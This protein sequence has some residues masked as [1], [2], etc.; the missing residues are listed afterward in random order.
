LIYR[1][2][3]EGIVAEVKN[4]RLKR[5]GVESYAI[6]LFLFN[7]LARSL[8]DVAL[9]P[10]ERDLAEL[11]MV[12][13]TEEIDLIREAIRIAE[14]ALT[15]ITPR[16]VPG[17]T[18]KDIATELEHEMRKK[19][20]NPPHFSIIVAAG[21]NG[22]LPHYQPAGKKIK[23]GEL[24][25]IDFGASF[26]GYTSDETV[27][28]MIGEDNKRA[29]EVYEVVLGAERAA[30]EAARAGVSVIDVDKAARDYIEERGYGQYFTHGTGHGVGL[31]VHEPPRISYIG[32]GKL[33]PGMVITIEPG[34]YIP[35]WGGVRIE[36]MVYIDE[37]GPEIL[38][39]IPKS[40]TVLS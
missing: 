13:E 10:I 21:E 33:E 4:L 35:G 6:P 14:T 2:K 28:F 23:P 24:V 36:D 9:V 25:T 11:R 39:T 3:I 30:I 32:E 40:F 26:S 7:A 29:R 31:N 34:V 16:I 27:T 12:K 20:S 8:P 19:G 15:E 22:A 1:K 18:E 17:V 38:T 5:L 37:N